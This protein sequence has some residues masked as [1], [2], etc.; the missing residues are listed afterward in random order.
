MGETGSMGV[1]WHSQWQHAGAGRVTAS[2]LSVWVSVWKLDCFPSFLFSLQPW[3]PVSVCLSSSI[4]ISILHAT[5]EYYQQALWLSQ[6]VCPSVHVWPSLCQPVRGGLTHSPFP[7]CS[8]MFRW[9]SIP[10]EPSHR[11]WTNA[12]EWIVGLLIVCLPCVSVLSGGDAWCW[13]SSGCWAFPS[14]AVPFKDS[15]LTLTSLGQTH[16]AIL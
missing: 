7:P 8:E 15:S 11:G 9:D 10:S 6:A 5:F 14:Y 13:D 1:M 2:G 3:T 4:C 16:W 12:G